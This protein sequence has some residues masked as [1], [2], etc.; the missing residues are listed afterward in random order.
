MKKARFTEEQI[1]AVLRQHEDGGTIRGL[2]HEHNIAEATFYNWKNK[3]GSTGASE[4]RRIKELEEENDRLK[5]MYAELSLD[6]M[7][8]KDQYSKKGN[9]PG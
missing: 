6:Y 8:L 9:L 1:L 7:L 4:A 2:C 3:Y 5:K